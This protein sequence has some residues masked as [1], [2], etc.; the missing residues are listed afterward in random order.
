MELFNSNELS[1]CYLFHKFVS[2]RNNCLE[3][4]SFK[5][6]VD[7]KSTLKLET[8]KE[9]EIIITIIIIIIII[10]ISVVLSSLKAS[11]GR[12]SVGKKLELFCGE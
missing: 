4:Y 2:G 11:T 12:Y 5:E 8:L 10:N 7:L 1:C 9:S 6:E 3:K